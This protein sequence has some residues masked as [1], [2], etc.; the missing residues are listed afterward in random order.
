MH[1]HRTAASRWLSAHRYQI[2]LAAALLSALALL[3]ISAPLLLV[4]ALIEWKLEPCK[5]RKPRLIGLLIIN[6]LLLATRWL[7]CELQGLPHR[8]WRPCAQCGKPIEA[9]SR[10]SYCSHA[11]RIYARLERDALDHDPRIAERAQRRLRNL[12]LRRL[13]DDDPTLDEVPF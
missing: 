8:P 1:T 2:T 12:R 3:L 10:A 7:W 6:Q 4:L 9:P 11:C 13:A 5:S